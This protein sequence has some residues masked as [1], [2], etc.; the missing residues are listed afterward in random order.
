MLEGLG[1]SLSPVLSH[2]VSGRGPSGD[3]KCWRKFTTFT[4]GYFVG[5]SFEGTSSVSRSSGSL[6]QPGCGIGIKSR[7]SLICGLFLRL[8]NNFLTMY[9]ASV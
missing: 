6:N 5:I 7:T 4:C 3:G 2:M 1:N 9:Q 8:P